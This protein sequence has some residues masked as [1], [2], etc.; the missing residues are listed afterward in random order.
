VKDSGARASGSLPPAAELS[1]EFSRSSG[2]GGQNVNKVSTAVRLRFDVRRSRSLAEDAKERLIG[3]A[4]RRVTGDGVL[5]I[6]ARR[7][8]TQDKNRQDALERL[9]DLLARARRRP[10]RRKRTKP[11]TQSREQRLEGKRRRS[12]IKKNRKLGTQY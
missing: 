7:F 5:I 11:T 8:R 6:E 2:P 1:F 9:R 4:G 3:L 12:A 10:K